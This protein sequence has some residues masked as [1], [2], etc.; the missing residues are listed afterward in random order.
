MAEHDPTVR[1]ATY[2][3]VHGGWVRDSSGREVAVGAMPVTVGRALSSDLRVDDEAVSAAHCELRA[4]ARGVRLR[5][6]GSTNGTL[7]G[8]VAVQDALLLRPCTIRLA[9]RS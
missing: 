3:Q 6:L 2:D 8:P 4:T 1:R 7:V 5:D 9:T